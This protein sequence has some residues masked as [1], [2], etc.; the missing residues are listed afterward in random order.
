VVKGNNFDD[1]IERWCF[2]SSF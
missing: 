2:W 1:F